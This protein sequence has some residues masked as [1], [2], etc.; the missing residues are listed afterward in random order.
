MTTAWREN[1]ILEDFFSSTLEHS[2]YRWDPSRRAE[3]EAAQDP[4]EFFVSRAGAHLITRVSEGQLR[5]LMVML[6]AALVA[7]DL[8]VVTRSRRGSPAQ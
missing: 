5:A 3:V 1:L 6:F 4:E 7:C 2:S 8:F